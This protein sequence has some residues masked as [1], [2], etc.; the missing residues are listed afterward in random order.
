MLIV[1]S[2]HNSSR[3]CCTY[4]SVI[5]V[6]F[7]DN[8]LDIDQARCS[9]MM[10]VGLVWA[11]VIPSR[12]CFANTWHNHRTSYYLRTWGPHV[13]GWLMADWWAW[14]RQGPRNLGSVNGEET[15]TSVNQEMLVF[16]KLRCGWNSNHTADDILYCIFLNEFWLEF[17]WRLFIGVQFIWS[18]HQFRQWLGAR[19]APSHYLKQ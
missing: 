12:Q 14:V 18:H 6:V 15:S 13:S 9:G 10:N 8:H 17:C 3:I 16:N 19:L 7:F 11:R 1:S 4:V 2:N 5:F